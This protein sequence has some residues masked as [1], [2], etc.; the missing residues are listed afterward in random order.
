[1]S[2]YLKSTT[3]GFE[4]RNRFSFHLCM[5]KI[6]LHLCQ[7]CPVSPLGP[8]MHIRKV[9]RNLISINTH[10]SLEYTFVRI[11]SIAE[12]LQQPSVDC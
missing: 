12:V 10:P 11:H 7:D 6:Y 9:T 1:M 3:S 2:R 5:L 4:I 8:Q